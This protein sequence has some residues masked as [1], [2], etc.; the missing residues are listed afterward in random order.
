MKNQ[1]ED[2]VMNK[3]VR[4]AFFLENNGKKLTQ[5]VNLFLEKYQ[6]FIEEIVEIRT[7]TSDKFLAVTVV[8]VMRENFD[9]T[10]LPS[11]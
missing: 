4:V 5:Q 1:V 3:N 9:S 2:I 11:V 7:Q 6:D 10:R 8:Y